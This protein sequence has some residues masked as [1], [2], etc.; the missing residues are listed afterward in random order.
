MLLEDN[1]Q[2]H[3]LKRSS[4]VELMEP[5]TMTTVQ[6]VCNQHFI[7][8]TPQQPDGRIVVWLPAKMDPKQLGSSRLSAERRLHA[9]E[10]RLERE[11]ELTVQYHNFMKEY[12]ELGHM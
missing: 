3:N 5:S 12:E 1:C 4:E 8:H 6:K 2:E 10:R 9:I 11:P 7:S